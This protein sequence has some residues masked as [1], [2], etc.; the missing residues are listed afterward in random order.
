MSL[1][2]RQSAQTQYNKEP[3]NLKGKNFVDACA[4][5]VS[6]EIIKYVR[7]VPD[8]DYLRNNGN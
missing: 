4:K 1:Q 2:Y 3:A 6:M 7:Y 5:M 8:K